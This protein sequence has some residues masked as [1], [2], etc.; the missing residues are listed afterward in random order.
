M[1]RAL[2][3]LAIGAAA[4]AAG[5]DGDDADPRSDFLKQADRICL[6]SGI[7]PT[8]VPND[9]RQAAALLAEEA[10]L[11]AAVHSKLAALKPPDDLAR[12]WRRFLTLTKEV[13]DSLRRMSAVARRDDPARLADLA[14]RTGATEDTRQRLGEQLGF[15]RCGRPITPPVREARP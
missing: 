4:A 1:R 9:N 7:R 3:I 10:R 2:T 13:A 6:R 15:R 14:R 12:D 8:A 11:R 5:C